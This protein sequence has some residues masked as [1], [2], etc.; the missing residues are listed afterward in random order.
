MKKD[1]AERL[2]AW[3]TQA[4]LDYYTAEFQRAGFRGGLNRYRNMDHD[5]EE[6]P[7]LAGARVEQ[8]ALFIAGDRDGVIAMIPN[9]VETMKQH[10]PN[11]RGVVMLPGA[12]HWTQ[13]ERPDEVNEALIAFLKGL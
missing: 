12:G 13:Q 1:A 6:L 7:Q 3:L 5:W 4:D 8:P 9:G 10:V 11:L 2:P